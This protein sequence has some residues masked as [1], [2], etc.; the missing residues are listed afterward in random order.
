[1]TRQIFTPTD[2]QIVSDRRRLHIHACADLTATKEHGD[3]PIARS[4]GSAS[5]SQCGVPPTHTPQV[6][7]R[8]EGR[9]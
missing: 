3:H 6:P 7:V 8:A 2:L 4:P 1:M 5:P 9:A